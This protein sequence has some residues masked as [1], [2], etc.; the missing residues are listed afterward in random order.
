MLQPK[1]PLHDYQI[2]AKNF[3]LQHPYAGLFLKMGLGKTSIVLEGLYELNPK[4]HVLIIAPKT[5]ARCTWINEIKKWNIPFR[6]QS[7]IVNKKGKNLSKKKREK[8]FDTIPTAPPTV[9]FINRD[10]VSKLVDYFPG[11]K[12][13]FPIVVIDESQSFKSYSSMR[14]KKLASVRPYMFRL[15]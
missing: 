6:T 9:Y 7:L 8:I 1:I 15:I 14:F 3:M 5:I 4:G 2:F 12:W 10:L 11:N 13:C